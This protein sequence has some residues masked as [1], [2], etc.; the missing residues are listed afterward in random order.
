MA[1]REG[2]EAFKQEIIAVHGPACMISGCEVLAVIEAAH[3]KPFRGVIDNSLG[4]GLLLR[5]DI[6]KLFDDLLLGVNPNTL[7]IKVA[8][9]ILHSEYGQFDGIRLLS[10]Q[11]EVL[12][13]SNLALRWHEFSGGSKKEKLIH[14]LSWTQ[15][16]R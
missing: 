16:T 15:G 14:D 5:S 9:S 7:E 6:H 13:R 8:D 12:D 4:N 1:L 11:L 2:Q 3:I 10:N